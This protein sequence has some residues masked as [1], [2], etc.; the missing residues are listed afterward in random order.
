[1]YYNLRRTGIAAIVGAITFATLPVSASA[2]FSTAFIAVPLLE[3]YAAY[4]IVY[5]NLAEI[6]KYGQIVL[7]TIEM[8]RTLIA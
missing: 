1:M 4:R 6:H 7:P 8:A 3:A 5:L 2:A